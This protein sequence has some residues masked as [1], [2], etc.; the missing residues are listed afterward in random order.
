MI[1][2][3][4]DQI[5]VITQNANKRKN[6]EQK[7]EMEKQAIEEKKVRIA[8]LEEKLKIKKDKLKVKKEDLIKHKK[9][10]DF[11]MSLVDDKKGDDQEFED[12]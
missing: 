1:N 7:L 11:L 8:E 5:S 6:E 10:N 12:I 4:R 3:V 9:F 2:H